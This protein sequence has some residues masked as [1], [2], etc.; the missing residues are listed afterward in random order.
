MGFRGSRVRIP[1]S[2]LTESCFPTLHV[3][4][5]SEFSGGLRFFC[6]LDP[7]W[8]GSPHWFQCSTRAVCTEKSGVVPKEKASM[9]VFSY[10]AVGSLTAGNEFGQSGRFG[11]PPGS[12]RF[13]TGKRTRALRRRHENQPGTPDGEQITAIDSKCLPIEKPGFGRRLPNRSGN[14]PG[15][16]LLTSI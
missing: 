2:R 3:R 12:L 5:P 8:L 7:R 10:T 14:A 9:G 1:P 15:K 16:C 4:R 11:K 6:F 13:A